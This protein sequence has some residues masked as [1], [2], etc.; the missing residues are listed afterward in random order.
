[1]T[2]ESQP[3]SY[4]IEISGIGYHYNGTVTAN[5]EDVV[6]LP[7]TAEV[8]SRGDQHQGIYFQTSSD[9][10]I[11]IGQNI[12]QSGTSSDTTIVL[13]IKELFVAQYVYY[14][15]S[16][17]RHRTSF[18]SRIVD[19]AVLVVSTEDNTMMNLT[20]TQP[21][22]IR[23]DD[24]DTNLTAGRQYSF[25]INRLQTVYVESEEDLTGTKVV[26]NKPVSV[27]SGH[28]C[29]FIPATFFGCDYIIEQIPPTT[30]WGTLHYVVPFAAGRS[31]TFKV[32]AAYNSTIVHI[33][34]NDTRRSYTISEGE[35]IYEAL[36][37]QEYCVIHSNKEVLVAQLGNKQIGNSLSVGGEMMTLVPATNQYSNK[38]VISTIRN[39]P[40]RG[41]IHYI[42]IIVLAQYYQPD[43]IY[44]ISGGVNK[45]LDTQEWVPV[46]VNNVTEAYAATVNISV[47][48][49]EIIH[50]DT[51]AL[52]TVI[53]Y[54]FGDGVG[55]GHTGE[56]V[57]TTGM[58]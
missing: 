43:M 52:M 33:Y 5:N 45:S 8:V 13:P 46:K 18:S 22:T 9:R 50:T 12:R 14:A 42:N 44:L 29:A 6:V 49:V 27:F 28:E 16:V 31:D 34:C 41:Y 51:S 39:S 40:D 26:T 57:F 48:A 24:T 3:V 30:L 1:M 23:V 38:F 20:V 54:G 4:A 2:T 11:L 37:M 10:V 56:L 47:G 7:C 21:V 35:F 17:P 25:V 32:L 19:S 53:V 58:F 15:M 55:Y 36:T